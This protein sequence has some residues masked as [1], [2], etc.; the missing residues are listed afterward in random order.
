M[1]TGRA[2]LWALLIR[3]LEVAAILAAVGVLVYALA[4]CQAPDVIPAQ[5]RAVQVVWSDTYQD[6][7]DPPVV[8]WVTQGDLDC[9]P[10]TDGRFRGFYRGRW[11]GD[12]GKSDA[13]VGGVTWEDWGPYCQVALPDGETFSGT[14][15]AHELY[16][17]HLHY[18]TGDGNASHSDP[19][20][21]V[22]FGHPYGLVDLANDRLSH[23]GL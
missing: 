8:S 9:A 3:V 22:A 15:F 1:S 6:L 14:A 12:V 11:Y 18:W 7:S 21:G 16:H 17:A 20:F 23:E 2:V 4:G 5:A 13:C 19:G 10:G